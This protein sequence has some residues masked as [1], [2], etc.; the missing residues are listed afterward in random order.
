MSY[1]NKR[2]FNL[3]HTTIFAI[4]LTLPL[5]VA[6]PSLCYN[7]HTVVHVIPEKEV[8]QEISSRVNFLQKYTGLPKELLLTLE[9]ECITHRIDPFLFVALMET[10]SNFNI[11]AKS[12]LGYYGLSQ[13]PWDIPWTDL[14][15][16]IGVR[17]F[18]EKI[19]KS[20]G[21][22]KEA[23]KKYK[24]FSANNMNS[25]KATKKVI[26]RYS[27]LKKLYEKQVNT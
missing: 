25:Q 5:V 10:E 8:Q 2:H 21:N 3:F 16:I 9:R 27:H 6:W 15:I 20:R 19:K 1:Y 14:N 24:G 22:V 7:P 18:A 17:I 4:C 26:E 13:I 23:I 11:E 12:G